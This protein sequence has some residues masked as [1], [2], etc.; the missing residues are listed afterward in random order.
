MADVSAIQVG[1]RVRPLIKHEIEQGEEIVWNTTKCGTI[2][3]DT[4]AYQ[5]DHV[6]NF[7]RETGGCAE[8]ASQTKVYTDFCSKV[9]DNAYG[10]FNG[11][12]FVY[13]QTGSGKSFTMFGGDGEIEGMIPRMGKSICN[14]RER[15]ASEAK[16]EI[17]FYVSFMEIY[18]D[19]LTDLLNP[20][21]HEGDGLRIREDPKTGVFT[22]GIVENAC[23]TPEDLARTVELGNAH[24][25]VA[26]TKMNPVSSRSH[27]VLVE[28]KI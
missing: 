26:A 3:H 18:G 23:A 13:G 24:R 4:H 11:C 20:A 25:T 16:G 27:A 10:G 12:L 19:R 21:G 22:P 6:W 1:I 7:N 8:E 5:F 9:V 28:R 15:R 17:E 2:K 14:E